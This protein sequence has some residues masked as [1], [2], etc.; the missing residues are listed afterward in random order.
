MASPP[1]RIYLK[2]ND[3]VDPGPARTILLWDER[4]DTISTGGFYLDMSGFPNNSQLTQFN[5]DLPAYYHAGAG[6]VSF[7][8]GHSIIK[9]WLDP[10]TTPALRNYDWTATGSSGQSTGLIIA[11]PNNADI[12]WLQNGGTRRIQP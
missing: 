9:R 3:L 2:F 12:I 5:W 7:A 8:D 10:R 6:G 1:W 4:E 11:S